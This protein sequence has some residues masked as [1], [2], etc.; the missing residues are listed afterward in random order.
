MLRYR[1]EEP[2][3][4]HCHDYPGDSRAIWGY[5]PSKA[6]GFTRSPLTRIRLHHLLPRVARRQHQP[7]HVQLHVQMGVPGLLQHPL[8]M[9]TDLRHLRWVRR[10]HE[11]LQGEGCSYGS[12]ESQI[13]MVG[14]CSM[15]QMIR[16][17]RVWRV[18]PDLL[19][20]VGIHLRILV[21]FFLDIHRAS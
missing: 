12:Q 10:H 21:I 1:Q 15:A 9:A 16:R 18:C 11:R 6:V 17:F 20:F 4:Q 8:G 19:R 14:G 7:R 13:R 2:T 5:V 3:L